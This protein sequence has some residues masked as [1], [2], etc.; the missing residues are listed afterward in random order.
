MRLKSV[1]GL[2]LILILLAVTNPSKDDYVA[3]VMLGKTQEESLVG[4]IA[5]ASKPLLQVAVE[6]DNYVFFSLYRIGNTGLT[7]GVLKTF[8]KLHKPTTPPDPAL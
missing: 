1:I 7:L 4:K 8:I 2:C 3:K 5:R 6:R